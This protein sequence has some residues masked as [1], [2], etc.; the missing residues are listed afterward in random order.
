MPSVL[1]ELQRMVEENKDEEK[2]MNG[3]IHEVHEGIREPHPVSTKGRLPQVKSS[4]QNSSQK[5]IKP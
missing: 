5:S 3:V 1:I 2:M 4:Q